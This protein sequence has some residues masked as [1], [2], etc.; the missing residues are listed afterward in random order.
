M[1]LY[2][3]ISQE[4]QCIYLPILITRFE[5]MYGR[6]LV[7][8]AEYHFLLPDIT[9]TQFL[10][11]FKAG[12]L[13]YCH[14]LLYVRDAPS[15]HIYVPSVTVSFNPIHVTLLHKHH[16]IYM[17]QNEVKFFHIK[18]PYKKIIIGNVQKS[19][20]VGY[21]YDFEFCANQ[22]LMLVLWKFVQITYASLH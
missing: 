21:V 7:H 14:V 8:F 20:W 1:I 19:P 9:K 11:T 18:Y 5:Q 3:V 22:I 12:D 13:L 16:D 15:C 17:H 10:L 2:I 4:E 6:R